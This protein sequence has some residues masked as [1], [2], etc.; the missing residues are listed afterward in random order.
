MLRSYHSKREKVLT[1]H[2]ANL[3]FGSSEHQFYNITIEMLKQAMLASLKLM[4]DEFIPINTR[5]HW[6]ILFQRLIVLLILTGNMHD[7]CTNT[8]L[9]PKSVSSNSK[10]GF[11]C[12]RNTLCITYSKEKICNHP[13]MSLSLKS[14][15]GIATWFTPWKWCM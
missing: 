3:S 5:V 12:A 1:N 13:K 10:F 15:P 14:L 2:Q 11:F 7:V 6:I 4:S 9:K 8:P